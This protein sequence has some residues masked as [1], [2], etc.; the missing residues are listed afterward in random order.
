VSYLKSKSSSGFNK[1]WELLASTLLI[2]V[3]FFGTIY[4]VPPFKNILDYGDKVTN[5]WEKIEERAPVPHAE[6]LT[7]SELTEQMKLS[8]VD[9]II[10]KLKSH[11]LIFENTNKQTLQEIGE[12]NNLTPI[13]VYEVISKK[14]ANQKQGS[15][16]GRK[17]VEDFALELN[18]SVDEIM[19]VLKANDIE[20]KATQTLRTI[21]ENNSLPPRDVYKLISE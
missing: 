1:K 17:T 2:F 15:G 21:G 5:S 16:I 3:F 19:K 10:R 12:A 9:E 11:K 18:K 20:A 7:L 13:E 4:G 6:Q 8:S 14:A